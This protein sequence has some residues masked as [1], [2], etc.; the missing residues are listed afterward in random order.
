MIKV[1]KFY[2]PLQLDPGETGEFTVEDEIHTAKFVFLPELR[3]YNTSPAIGGDACHL[4][5]T[6][7]FDLGWGNDPLW[8]GREEYVVVNEDIPAG[9]FRAYN[10]TPQLDKAEKLVTRHVVRITNLG[11]TEQRIIK[12][13]LFG[14]SETQIQL[15]SDS[16]VITTQQPN[17]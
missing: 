14:L 10:F 17:V 12:S 16:G 1:V 4:E 5:I 7:I 3:V 11:A 2:K 15:G 13:L 9:A 8:S 6:H